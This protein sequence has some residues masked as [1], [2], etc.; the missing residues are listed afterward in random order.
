MPR[1]SVFKVGQQTTRPTPQ[2]VGWEGAWP[3]E[4]ACGHQVP[5]SAHMGYKPHLLPGL[6]EYRAATLMDRRDLENIY[7]WEELGSNQ[8][9]PGP[10]QPGRERTALRYPVASAVST[11]VGPPGGSWDAPPHLRPAQPR[12]P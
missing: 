1:A 10:C 5:P 2:H 3:S 12:P 9:R 8:V 4:T 11:H 6:R 7:T